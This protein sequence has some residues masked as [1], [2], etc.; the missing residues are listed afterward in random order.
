MLL[1]HLAGL[2]V[3]RVIAAG[4]TVRVEACSEVSE[5]WC[6][7]C[8]GVSVRVHSRYERRLSDRAISAQAVLLHLTMRRFFCDNSSCVRRP[9]AEQFP[10]LTR[11]YG[12][13][14]LLLVEALRSIALMVDGRLV[15][16][17][18]AVGCGGLADNAAAPAAGDAG[19]RAENGARARSK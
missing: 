14:T 17:D 13:S 10:K 1:P 6:P 7:D 15:A 18:R 3:G 4:R 12:R 5:A 8:G 16:A 19:A 9:F 11:R 2:R